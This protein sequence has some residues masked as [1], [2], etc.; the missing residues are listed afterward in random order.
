MVLK[1]SATEVLLK[2]IRA[3]LAGKYWIGLEGVGDLVE[4]V[5]SIAPSFRDE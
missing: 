4:A 3:V 2:S 1:E 5:R